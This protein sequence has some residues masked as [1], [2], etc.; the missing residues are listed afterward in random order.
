MN[1]ERHK[2]GL[3]HIS[4]PNKTRNIEAQNIYV[5]FELNG[6]T[7][8]QSQGFKTEIEAGFYPDVS[9]LIPKLN[10]ALRSIK[11]NYSRRYDVLAGGGNDENDF[12]EFTYD[13]H[14]E[15]VTLS[16]NREMVSSTGRY[17]VKVKLTKRLYVK[18]GFGLESDYDLDPFIVPQCEFGGS[19]R[20]SRYV[21]DLNLG[22][23]CLFIYLDVIE[24][25]RIVGDQLTS[26][27]AIVPWAGQHNGQTFFEPKITEYCT[28]RYDV[29]DEINV[30]LVG[31]TGEILDFV[32]GKVFLT[33]HIKDIF[34]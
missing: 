12:L 18:L 21:A 25:D 6:S 14:S 16:Y 24:K 29:I 8:S 7:T 22:H 15:M 28:L 9:S 20:P 10:N 11:E 32:S 34:E 4:W 3:K 33:L 2:I 30:Q 27:L 5:I 31:D 17:R 1:R 13:E 23:T 26:L 19:G